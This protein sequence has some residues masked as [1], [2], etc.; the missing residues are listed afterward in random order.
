[1]MEGD[2]EAS[3]LFPAENFQKEGRHGDTKQGDLEPG[4]KMDKITN[5]GNL[6]S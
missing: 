6:Q 4:G 5:L 3:S 2:L 1:M